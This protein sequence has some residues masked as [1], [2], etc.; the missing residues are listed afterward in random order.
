MKTETATLI[1]LDPTDELDIFIER[2]YKVLF[3]IQ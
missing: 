2:Q 3:T 1:Q